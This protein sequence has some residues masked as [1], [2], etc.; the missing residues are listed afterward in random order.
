MRAARADLAPPTIGPVGRLLE[1]SRP[2]QE[3]E[4]GHRHMSHLCELHPGRQFTVDRLDYHAAARKTLE[5]R[6]REML[7]QSHDGAI[8]LL[9]ALPEAWPDGSVTGLRAR[10][11]VTFD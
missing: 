8:T 11:G 9:P 5:H 6:H 1:W 3:P 10:G 4:P 2:Y 7:L